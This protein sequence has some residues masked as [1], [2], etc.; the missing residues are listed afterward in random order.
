MSL[1]S[2]LSRTVDRINQAVGQS[3]IWLVLLAVLIS[4]FNA[5]MRKF[6]NISSNAFLELQWYLFS[7]VF[8]LSGA[9]TLARNGHVRIDLLSGRLSPKGQAWVDVVGIVLFLT[10]MCLLVIITAWPVFMTSY[11]TAEV[12]NNAG[13]LILWPARLLVPVGFTLLLLQGFSELYKRVCVINGNSPVD[14]QSVSSEPSAEEQLAE[15][16]RRMR[17]LQ[18]AS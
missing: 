17:G 10:P 14:S 11:L 13:G 8:L 5:L 4:T 16:I 9:Y 1:G 12:S 3:V 7:G 18:E 15:E 2:K 6:L